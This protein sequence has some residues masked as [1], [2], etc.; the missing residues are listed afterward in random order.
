MDF[1]TKAVNLCKRTYHEKGLTFVPGDAEQ[2]PFD[3]QSFDAVVNVE[4]SHC[5]ASM[6]NFLSEV[7]R[8]LRPGGHFLFADFR[9][10]DKLATLDTQLTQTGMQ[11]VRQTNITP[12][13]VAALDQDHTRKLAQIQ[14]H[15][16]KLLR[17]LFQ[18]FAGNQGTRIYTR[19]REKIAIYQSFVF[20]KGTA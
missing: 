1:S 9:Y 7:T 4:S 6:E 13:I 19:F 11:R 8:V 12:N 15:S 14:K 2:I 3:D 10:Q 20:Q 17:R 16:P 18:E 5:Y